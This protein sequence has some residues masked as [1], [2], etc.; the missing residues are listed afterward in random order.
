MAILKQ[1]RGDSPGQIIELKADK[2]MI[3]RLAD[4]CQ[5]FLK[6]EKNT[7]SREHADVRRAGGTFSLVDLH[8]TSG[9]KLNNVFIEPDKE[10]KLKQ[11]DRIGI[12]EFEFIFFL[13]PPPVPLLV[14]VTPDPGPGHSTVH[15]LDA[16]PS[17]VMAS[18]V[19]SKIKLKAIL[20]IAR[21]LSTELEIDKVAPKILDS[22]MELY[23][24][25][26]RLFLVLVDAKTQTLVP[27]AFKY[28]PNR[29]SSGFES[30]VPADEMRM[31]ISKTIVDLVLGQKQ[32]VLSEDAGN[33]KNL[34][35]GESIA[36]LKIRS[37]MCVP[38]LTP[39]GQALG[40]IQLD[41]SDRKQFSQDDLNVLTAVASQA[42]IAIQN[43]TMH[44]SLIEAERLKGELKIAEEVVKGLLP[45]SVP[46]VPGYEFFAY[47]KAAFEIGGDYYDFVPLPNNRI[48]LVLGDVMGHGIAAALMMARFS[49]YTRLC[50]LTESS[51][52][53]A[54]NKLN[55]LLCGAGLGDRFI[56]LSLSVLDL[57]ERRLTLCSAGHPRIMVRRQNG[58]IEEWGETVAGVPLGLMPNT[59]YDQ[60]EDVLNPGDVAV[61][62][63]DGVTDALSPSGERYDTRENRRLFRRVA[64]SPGGPEEVGRAILQ[65]IREFSAGHLQ[66]DDLTLMCFGPTAG[67]GG[68][69]APVAC[70]PG[71]SD[72]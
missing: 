43:A 28:R 14:D 50:I 23:P 59:T 44:E 2:N 11:G 13:T 8:S 34:P 55:A 15:T 36:D 33:D 17:G 72:S 35:P 30:S 6:S 63:S 53:A 10:Y 60:I 66:A 45:Q 52:A 18:A 7:V 21:N 67:E 20:E 9:T 3:G 29:R 19:K 62:Y 12:C 49:G 68:R 24:Q 71:R 40:I 69:V 26:D 42:A 41:T 57:A 56:T 38:L 47:Y 37:V 46:T 16:S 58:A 70:P 22:L 25:A 48:A 5:I 61:I 54:A 4:R 32:A 64:E 51:P 65:E 39:D 1:I 27:K 31:S